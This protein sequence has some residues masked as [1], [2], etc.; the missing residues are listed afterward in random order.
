MANRD[1]PMD[2]DSLESDFDNK[3]NTYHNNVLPCTEKGY[4]ELDVS[5][6]NMKLR[7]SITPAA[8]PMSRSFTNYTSNRSLDNDDSLNYSSN[9]NN[10]TRSLN[11]N[12]S[13]NENVVKSLKTLPLQ[14]LPTDQVDR[15]TIL[16]QLDCVEL[17]GDP[18]DITVTVS[19]TNDDENISLAS[20]S[21]SALHSPD[22][23]TPTKEPEKN[24]NESPIM[25]G[26]K[27]VLN[28]FRSSQSPIPP[29]DND[30][31]SNQ[32]SPRLEE[33]STPKTEETTEK[34][35]SASTPIVVHRNKDL[36][37]SNRNSPYKESVTFNEDLEKEL[38]WKDETTILFSQE[39]IPVHKLFLTKTTDS[40]LKNVTETHN[41]NLNKTVE[42][43]DMSFNDMLEDKTL[44]ESEN[45]KND[46]S[47]V[48]SDSEFVDCETTFTKDENQKEKN[49]FTEEHMLNETVNI[50]GTDV[51]DS[52]VI[53]RKP[54]PD[55]RHQSNLFNA[56]NITE[57]SN[58]EHLNH[59]NVVQITQIGSK[60]ICPKDLQD[61]IAVDNIATSE[62]LEHNLE[63]ELTQDICMDYDKAYA[64]NETI[65][66]EAVVEQNGTQSKINEQVNRTEHTQ[67]KESTSCEKES[68]LLKESS[69]TVT[70]LP[71]VNVTC[72]GNEVVDVTNIEE[73]IKLPCKSETASLF[74]MLKTMQE[75]DFVEKESEDI[76]E[77]KILLDES[78]TIN[79]ESGFDSL[80]NITPKN[81]GSTPVHESNEEKPYVCVT[82]ENYILVKTP[83]A[84]LPRLPSDVPLPDEDEIENDITKCS[85]FPRPRI[86]ELDIIDDIET[87][88]SEA[89]ALIDNVVNEKTLFFLQEFGNNLD[90]DI[91]TLDIHCE[92]N[93]QS[94]V[95]T[96]ELKLNN[97]T[98]N[99]KA[100]MDSTV[101]EEQ[102]ISEQDNIERH[103]ADVVE[104]EQAPQVLPDLLNETATVVKVENCKQEIL[105]LS[106]N[107]IADL[108]VKSNEEQQ[109]TNE[110]RTKLDITPFEAESS[111]EKLKD[112]SMLLKHR[113]Q[114]NAIYNENSDKNDEI[115]ELTL[116]NNEIT[117]PI[118]TIE[119]IHD[120]NIVDEEIKSM[121]GAISALEEIPNANSV[122]SEVKSTTDSACMIES[123]IEHKQNVTLLNKTLLAE[124]EIHNGKN[125]QLTESSLK[126]EVNIDSKMAL[127]DNISTI[128]LNKTQELEL[129]MTSVKTTDDKTEIPEVKEGLVDAQKETDNIQGEVMDDELITSENNSPYVSV[130]L[131]KVSQGMQN[132]TIENLPIANSPPISSKGYNFNFD[133]M[134]DPFSTK[135]N[136]RV[137]PAPETPIQSVDNKTDDKKIIEL[138]KKSNQN[139]RKSYLDRKRSNLKRNSKA[140]SESSM[141]R[142]SDNIT[143]QKEM[144]SISQIHSLDVN[145][146]TKELNKIPNTV[147][148]ESNQ[149]IISVETVVKIEIQ[150]ETKSNEEKPKDDE[151]LETKNE[152]AEQC[153]SDGLKSRNVFNLPEIDDMNFNPFVTKSKM[154]QSP[155]PVHDENPF[156]TRSK[157][158]SSP[159]SSLMMQQDIAVENVEIA[160]S[161][162]DG[163]HLIMEKDSV[164]KMETEAMEKDTSVN[165]S[166]STSSKSNDDSAITT[167][168]HTEDEDTIEG[169]FLE[170]EDDND[171]NATVDHKRT[172]MMN[173]SDAPAAEN[174]ENAEGEL[175]I[176][177]EAFEF[178]LNQNKTNV[179]AD[180]GK[181]SLFLK[182]DPLFA[183][184]MSTESMAAA[185]Q[186]IQQRQSTPTKNINTQ[187]NFTNDAGPSTLNVTFETDYH[188]I[189]GDDLNVT[190]TKPMMV[191]TPAVNPA[192]TRKS[193]T[194][195]R[196]NRRS[197]TFTSPA[198]AVIDRLLSLSGNNTVLEPEPTQFSPEQY[199]A[200]L[201]LTQLREILA[202]KETHVYNLRSESKELK[203]RLT[204]L[205]SQMKV[206]ETEGQ[207][208]LQKINDLNEKLAEKTKINKS[209]AAVVEEY[210]RTI[211]SLIAD[212]EQDKK[213]HAEER[214]ALIN[215]RDEQTAHLASM[216]VSF[217][218]LHSKYE[219]SKQVILSYKANEEKYKNSLKEM[220]ENVTKMHKNYELLKQHATS[221]LNHAND[222]LQRLNRSHEAE[223]V[224]L[225][226][227]IKRKELHITSLE[228]T[229]AQKTKA[230]EELTAICDELI[231][232]VG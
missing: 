31:G 142:I 152:S 110:N 191:V 64:N 42:Y 54:A 120:I 149:T 50:C 112:A 5:E 51:L 73:K 146:V 11:S 81:N 179:V 87:I 169:P 106:A 208:R 198:M 78:N 155:L 137:S 109:V 111:P 117:K 150:S 65:C 32:I 71:N 128:N 156:A 58:E 100:E 211:A 15:I 96:E 141:D 70:D 85:R 113:D 10:L 28:I 36:N 209:M 170:L 114:N 94:D 93:L 215:E 104:T 4:E 84:P 151:I 228:E 145:K 35:A 40:Q 99:Q 129:G 108:D 206:L 153:Y 13:K 56:I 83:G 158:Q 118:D 101:K 177:A 161:K 199:E 77:K 187:E 231:N 204:N 219:K 203:E 39:K 123:Q 7:Y 79:E 173:F 72:L 188:S 166:V 126:L 47:T 165:I 9:E 8:S 148:D 57:N 68:Q 69:S 59:E 133:D 80:E 144:E 195:T 183:K 185:L 200:D 119:A 194:P 135:T 86:A 88:Q 162:L 66:V 225:N 193:T 223:V 115:S 176:D 168:I 20:S 21:S 178:L 89:M 45:I 134:E 182:F 140:F 139:K 107:E 90:C 124:K 60:L 175:F 210:E 207:Q 49:N 196:S 127:N 34:T 217:N 147:D 76:K 222:E 29:G 121:T 37:I 125:T 180:S 154:C 97:I 43:M 92:K 205:E 16:Q 2:I 102:N 6:L 116:V 230:N 197:I 24:E 48:E 131:D 229:L 103:L 202:E 163:T 23:T 52:S 27:S 136:I 138:F 159:D 192:P 53:E 221:K 186:K 17:T 82:P 63:F 74:Q 19:K 33:C 130:D 98:I 44:T 160:E 62:N 105:A 171:A 22:A 212:T 220:E 18:H 201:A 55:E 213:R 218:D 157:I 216:E 214:I 41:Q 12:I 75:T 26:L 91:T 132:E 174:D 46:C 95:N 181:E 232:K 30:V 143:D 172:D 226:A 67:E 227:M 1:E 25:R 61:T 189:T 224:K 190:V 122:S 14:S 167:E 164:D 38:L 3:E 184:R